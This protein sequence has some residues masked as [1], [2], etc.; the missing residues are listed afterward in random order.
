[1]QFPNGL[2]YN[3]SAFFITD[4][5]AAGEPGSVRRITIESDGSAGTVTTLYTGTGL[6]DDL[7]VVD[8]K[9]LVSGFQNGDILLID[10][11]GNLEQQTTLGT[12]SSAS[13]VL[14]A[15]PPMFGRNDILV[16]EKG[17]LNEHDSNV[18]NVLSV[19]RAN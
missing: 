3:G 18:G 16:T 4:S 14:I 7:S 10:Q 15:K 11:N 8:D 5:N 13:S 17:T 1:M 2:A 6:L 12:F 19:F 9:L